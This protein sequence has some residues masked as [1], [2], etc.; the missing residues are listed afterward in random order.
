MG[1]LATIA[2][3]LSAWGVSPSPS[4]AKRGRGDS[5]STPVKGGTPKQDLLVE[6]G[7]LY[8]LTTFFRLPVILPS[9]VPST[10]EEFATVVAVEDLNFVWGLSTPE[11]Q[12]LFAD[13]SHTLFRV[14]SL[15]SIVAA[16]YD[17]VLGSCELLKERNK[18]RG[19]CEVLEW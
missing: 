9:L 1:Q 19:S 5:L 11:R 4:H 14:R 17:G 7:E 16:G 8:V 12:S 10:P 3:D 15:V 13:A 18:M 6:G 2:T